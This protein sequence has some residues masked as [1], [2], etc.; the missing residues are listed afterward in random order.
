MKAPV[1]FSTAVLI[2]AALMTGCAGPS[3]SAADPW[4]ITVDGNT[5]YVS[6]LA[7]V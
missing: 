7:E 1:V 5:A 2:A 3:L 4:L 6:D